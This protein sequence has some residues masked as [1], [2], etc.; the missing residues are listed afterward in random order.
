MWSVLIIVAW[1]AFCV[2]GTITGCSGTINANPFAVGAPRFINKVQNG[3]RW[4]VGEGNDTINVVH[5]YGSPYDQ[6]VAY[7]ML[8]KNE[9]PDMVSLFY[10]WVNAQIDAECMKKVPSL[11]WFCKLIEQGHDVD[12]LL[13]LTINATEP[14]TPTWFTDELRGIA[15]G[16]GVDFQTLYRLNM[17]PE[18]IR[19]ACTMSGSWG[20]A[21]PG[22]VG[23][24]Q[25]RALDEGTDGPMAKYPLVTV[26]H[27]DD[28]SVPGA[29]AYANIGWVGLTG[30]LSGYSSARMAISEKVMDG[31]NGSF[32]LAGIPWMVNLKS[33]MMFDNTV[34]DSIA[35]L[36]SSERTCAIFVGVGGQQVDATLTNQFR[37]IE[38][39]HDFLRV[40]DDTNYT[41]NSDAH[42]HLDGVMYWD[43]HVQPSNDMCLGSILS[44]YHGNLTA[45]TYATVV[46][47]LAQTGDLHIA[48]YDMANSIVYTS[49]AAY[50]A[51]SG[52]VDAWNR[53][54]VRLD[55]SALFNQ[56]NE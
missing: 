1:T 22:A 56:N 44:T 11:E 38:Y 40:F 50:G 34:A 55:M 7:G 54:F 45:E 48:T 9:L 42:P 52:P 30:V 43:K 25:L 32:A 21:V 8:F 14:F 46:A 33:I 29:H 49:N 27:P 13:D 35:R 36:Q 12:I 15:F 20:S 41:L 24:H 23:I 47:P 26:Y 10:D 6:G 2:Q 16:S 39:S 4:I 28:T 3:S 18:L 19:A 37:G 53:Q 31:Y 51:E 17:F 5:V